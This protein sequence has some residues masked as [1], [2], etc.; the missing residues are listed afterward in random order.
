MGIPEDETEAVRWYRQAAEQGISEAQAVIGAEYY[1]GKILPKDD[2][3]AVQWYRKAADQDNEE[4]Q[5]NLAYMY[6]KGFGVSKDNIQSYMWMRL[7]A[8]H[9]NPKAQSNLPGLEES[10]TPEQIAEGK[11]RAA[12]WKPTPKTQLQQP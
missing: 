3:K 4:A 10:M 2:A 7:A 6:R 9:S 8:G 11:H 1:T 5:Y 12:E